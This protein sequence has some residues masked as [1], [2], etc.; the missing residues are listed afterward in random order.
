MPNRYLA[1]KMEVQ[2]K[3]Y[4]P[5]K[6]SWMKMLKGEY[7]KINLIDK[8][9]EIINLIDDDLKEYIIQK[10]YFRKIT[11]PIKK[12]PDKIKSISLDKQNVLDEKLIGIKGQYLI[13]ES[14]HVFNVRRHTGYF[15]DFSI[16]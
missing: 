12:Y 3:Q 6:T 13:F 14:N 11:F 1:G 16:I 4:L 2:L 7:D 10:D 8:K 5:D 9:K 15:V